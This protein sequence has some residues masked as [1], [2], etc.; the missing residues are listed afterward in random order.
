MI[1]PYPPIKVEK[2]ER[3]GDDRNPAVQLFGRRFFRDQTIQELLNE[4]LLV[5]SAPKRIG[6]DCIDEEIIFPLIEKLNNWPEQQPL[7]YAPKVRLN[8]KLFSFLSSSKLETR[9]QSHKE[10]YHKYI[11]K[12]LSQDKLLTDKDNRVE[13]LQTL[14]NLFAGFRGIVTQRTW[15]AKSFL[16]IAKEFVYAETLWNETQARREDI[17]DWKII[18]K[19]FAHFFSLNRHRFLARGGELLYL[20]ICNALSQEKEEIKKW[21]L[22]T[23]FDFEES[24]IIPFSLHERLT[25]SIKTIL[26]KYSGN[27]GKLAEFID[28]GIE[29]ETSKLT[30]YN[31]ENKRRYTK[32]GWCPSE[33]WPEG[34]LFALELSR[35]TEAAIDPMDRL[36]LMQIACAFQVLRSLCAQSARHVPWVKEKEKHGNTFNYVWVISDPVG[37]HDLLKQVSRRCLNTIQKMLYDAIRIEEIER[38]L[39]E[40]K[41]NDEGRWKNPYK[42]ADTRYGYKLFI[43]LGKRIG[44]IVPRRGPGARFVLNDKLVRFL[45]MTVIRPGEKI[46]Y[47]TFKDLIYLHYGIAI[48]KDKVCKACEWCENKKLLVLGEEIEEWFVDM[49]KSSGVL[50]H[51][52]DSHSI[53]ENPFGGSE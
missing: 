23:G 7:E 22:E 25:K 46:R 18:I 53:V 44:F 51:L 41:E 37:N 29:A 14:E 33:S 8:L 40:Q 16:P 17:N 24:E 45:V 1:K 13:V 11:K 19:R 12:F 34:F 47:N 5:A 31:N 30:E 27:L 10:H 49:L 50:T 32:C 36:E 38:T 20:Q 42:E 4:F 2:I 48:D 39:E 43:T 6:K 3:D 26:E 28:T 35:I 15:C 21:S 9:H 52:S